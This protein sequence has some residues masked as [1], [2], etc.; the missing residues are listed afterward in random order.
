MPESFQQGS[1][2]SYGPLD[3][4]SSLP[5][6]AMEV[7]Q[8]HQSRPLSTEI[9]RGCFWRCGNLVVFDASDLSTLA[10]TPLASR[11]P[12]PKTGTPVEQRVPDLSTF[13]SPSSILPMSGNVFLFNLD[14]KAFS[15]RTRASVIVHPSQF[16]SLLISEGSPSL[17]GLP[18][19]NP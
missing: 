11:K 1:F 15:T 9:H 12:N 4:P 5:I 3:I 13:S 8:V 18:H 14:S 6:T 10:A 19:R 7:S 2:D 16:R 17:L